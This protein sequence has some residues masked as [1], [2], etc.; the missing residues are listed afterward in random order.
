MRD[1]IYARQQG[2][3]P[4][5]DKK[6]ADSKAGTK[7]TPNRAPPQ[8][9]L[10]PLEK[11]VM[12]RKSAME[13]EGDYSSSEWTGKDWKMTGNGIS[14]KGLANQM[15]NQAL[16]SCNPTTVTQ[17]RHDFKVFF[18]HSPTVLEPT[19][20][21]RPEHLSVPQE[22]RKW[23]NVESHHPSQRNVRL[24]EHQWLRLRGGM[25]KHWRH[26]HPDTALRC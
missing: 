8:R 7:P 2:A 22:N 9:T 3:S 14:D 16:Q 4:M 23:G 11:A 13:D 10:T 19:V 24:F 12:S 25:Q 26:G 15:I 17:S 5:S 20:R 6:A 1:E 21:H 18:F